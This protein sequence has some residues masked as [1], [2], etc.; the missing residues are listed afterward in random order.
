MHAPLRL[1][2]TAVAATDVSFL[3]QQT[4]TDTS[5]PMK[6]RGKMVGKA[7]KS[8]ANRGES[9][10]VMKVAA[11]TSAVAAL[12][13]AIASLIVA[14]A[15]IWSSKKPTQQHESRYCKPGCQ[16]VDGDEEDSEVVTRPRG[17]SNFHTLNLCAM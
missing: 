5:R 12:L 3:S 16:D 6:G 4:T 9:A 13:S 1:I 15:P 17:S 14:A 10:R 7:H 8:R 2:L 11:I